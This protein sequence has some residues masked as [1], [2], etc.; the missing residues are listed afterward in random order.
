MAVIL[1][2]PLFICSNLFRNEYSELGVV[3]EYRYAR[4]IGNAF[5]ADRTLHSL[6]GLGPKHGFMPSNDSLVFIHASTGKQTE[7]SELLDIIK[8]HKRY[9]MA[10]AFMLA[11]PY[12]IPTI[13]SSYKFENINQGITLLILK[14]CLHNKNINRS[15]F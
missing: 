1:K 3:T 10:L 8:E 11:H 12:G 9:Q 2:R 15:P 7:K 14:V 4:D 13:L 5:Q 6:L